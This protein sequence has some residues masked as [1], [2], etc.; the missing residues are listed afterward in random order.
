VIVCARLALTDER[1]QKIILKVLDSI[2]SKMT[3]AGHSAE[4]ANLHKLKS[5]FTSC[6]GIVRTWRGLDRNYLTE[7]LASGHFEPTG[8]R[9][10]PPNDR[11]PARELRSIRPDP[12]AGA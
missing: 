6:M 9:P 4:E 1:P 11:L 3:D 12:C 5:V 8:A 2:P 10:A 7:P